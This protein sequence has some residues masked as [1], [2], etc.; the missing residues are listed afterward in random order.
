MV[1]GILAA[2]LWWNLLAFRFSGY[3]HEWDAYHYY[4]GAK[5]FR[6]LGYTRLY[7]CATVAD[8]EDG[9]FPPGHVRY[10]R[11]L[12]TNTLRRTPAVLVD[13]VACKRH[14]SDERWASFRHDVGWFRSQMSARYWERS[15]T[16]HGFNGT[17]VWAILGTTLAHTGP[18][19][20]RQLLALSLIDHVLVLAMWAA[21]ASA[22]GWRTMMAGLLYW[23]TN[24]PADFSWTG[25]GYLRQD[26]LAASIVGVCLLRTGRPLGAGFL[27]ATATL[28]RLFPGLMLGGLLLQ[29]AWPMWRQRTLRVPAEL[30][31]FALG[32]LAAVLLLV[33]LS[34]VMAGGW[35]AWPEF[36]ANTR[37]HRDTPLTNYV[38]LKTVVSYEHGTRGAVVVAQPLEEDAWSVWKAAR[39][40]VFAERWLLF[41]ALVLGFVVLLAWA[42]R[43]QPAWVALVLG[44]GLVPFTLELTCYY[45]SLMVA[46]GLLWTRSKAV[47]AVLALL[48]GAT[49]LAPW[50]TSENDQVYTLVSALI[51]VFVSFATARIAWAK[52]TR[53]ER[54]IASLAHADTGPGARASAS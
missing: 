43:D 19:S 12:E 8:L 22:F 48:A 14:F 21:V 53:R 51:V 24:F 2:L 23:G 9:A 3:I 44:V 15:F 45:Y 7:L 34:T 25:G 32:G 30:R 16:D 49:W 11:D 10:M 28:L 26:W 29:A 4:V 17:P 13:Q 38:G 5:Y 6:E 20:T 40:R 50:A 37:K 42:V 31:R 46:Y 18:A 27:L 33:P 35:G 1:V 47:P 52:P 39:Q 54:P 36:V 41:A